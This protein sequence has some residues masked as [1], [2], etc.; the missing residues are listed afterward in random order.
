MSKNQYVKK[1]AQSVQLRPQDSPLMA[2]ESTGQ[3]QPPEPLKSSQSLP[4]A[5]VRPSPDF[6]SEAVSEPS[7]TEPVG[8]PVA[9]APTVEETEEQKRTKEMISTLMEY[10]RPMVRNPSFVDYVTKTMTEKCPEFFPHPMRWRAK[11]GPEQILARLHDDQWVRSMIPTL[12]ILL[13]E[14]IKNVKWAAQV[15]VAHTVALA[16]IE[17]PAVLRQ[18]GFQEA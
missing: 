10:L 7:E 1:M 11:G 6:P 17:L 5:A 14:D 4:E 13:G 12:W 16:A 18:K 8:A 9:S 2:N 3:P 15:L